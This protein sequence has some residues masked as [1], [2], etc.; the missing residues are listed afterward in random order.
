MLVLPC[1]VMWR[2]AVWCEADKCT[3]TVI[4]RAYY[5]ACVPG[6]TLFGALVMLVSNLC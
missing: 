5:C 1:A 2:G 4:A 6:F 3:R